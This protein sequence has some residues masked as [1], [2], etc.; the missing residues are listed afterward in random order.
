MRLQVRWN[1]RAVAAGVLALCLGGLG[2]QA[3][4]SYSILNKNGPPGTVPSGPAVMAD[5]VSA[6]LKNAE[7]AQPAPQAAPA[8]QPVAVLPAGFLKPLPATQ[9]P[10]DGPKPADTQ[11]K[12]EVLPQAPDAVHRCCPDCQAPGAGM[13]FAGEEEI[14]RELAKVSLPPYVIEPPDILLI[15]ALKLVP[16]PPYHIEP[17]DVLQIQVAA[18]LPDQPVNGVYTVTP[19]GLLVLGFSYGA[20][21]VAGLTLEEAEAAIRNQLARSLKNPQIALA[22]A[23]FRGLQ[24]TRGEHL[25]RP[26]GT[27]SLGTY[28]CVYVTG[29]TL[30]QA[31]AAIERHLSQ[32]ILNPEISLDVFAYNSK[33]YYVITDGGGFGQQVFRFPVTGNETVLDAIGQINGLPA[34]AS[35]RKI[36]V[37][38]PAPAHWGCDQVLPVDW[39]AI[40]QGGSTNTNYQIFP[41][42]RIYVKADC[43]IAIDNALAKLF[44]PIERI[45]GITLLGNFTARSFGSGGGLNNTGIR[46]F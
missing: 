40:T 18:T 8:V 27:I 29:L 10:T 33:V 31:R 15:D 6:P 45:F 13:H 19:D 2:C 24:Q 9:Q 37:A 39:N 44:S 22:L 36:W 46:G 28:G 41:G 12:I 14:P 1:V 20:V 38:R 4:L 43:L 25:V 11:P 5:K 26:D 3:Q 32:F 42:D 34:V 21:R 7:V 16:L 35:K 23:Q 17:L 30:C